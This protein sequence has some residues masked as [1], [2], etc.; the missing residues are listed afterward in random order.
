VR[1]TLGR[2]LG[3]VGATIAAA[4]LG[5]LLVV[6]P[7]PRVTS[8]TSDLP[9]VRV[10]REHTDA[11]LV[12][13]FSGDGGWA[14]LPRSIAARLR[15]S[16]LEVVGWNS[17]RYFWHRRTAAETAHSLEAVMEAYGSKDGR[18]VFL[19]G[20]S[21]GADV[22]PFVVNRLS[23]PA[24]ARVEGVALLGF[25]P[26]AAFQF[27]LPGWLDVQLGPTYPTAPEVRLLAERGI[28]VLCVN[29]T[30]ERHQGCAH[31]AGAGVA[32]R[33]IQAGHAF[34]GRYRRLAAL[35]LEFANNDAR[36]VSGGN[37]RQT[38]VVSRRST[39]D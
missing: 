3:G 17:L 28:P 20:Y 6:R 26:R 23:A 24:R 11:P 34:H 18:P 4:A 32:T 29:G 1:V 7:S 12:V 9:L 36:R 15:G 10:A 27:H 8:S 21:F 30:A 13:F 38:T 5:L 35:V 22:L 33:R 37:S 2:G 19:V 25:A 39:N 16:G 14:A 31:V